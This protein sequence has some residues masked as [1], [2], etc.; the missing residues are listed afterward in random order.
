PY[1]RPLAANVHGHRAMVPSAATTGRQLRAL[2]VWVSK[3][4]LR[5]WSESLGGGAPRDAT[6]DNQPVA[7]HVSLEAPVHPPVAACGGPQ[8]ERPQLQP[9]SDISTPG[10]QAPGAA[11]PPSGFPPPMIPRPPPFPS[12]HPSAPLA[13]A[14]P[15]R[16]PLMLPALRSSL[17]RWAMSVVRAKPRWAGEGRFGRI[18]STMGGGR[19]LWPYPVHHAWLRTTDM[20]SLWNPEAAKARRWRPPPCA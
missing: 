4:P 8:A 15:H 7:K 13:P 19:P 2:L 5:G 20:P 14:A 17:R 18:P 1:A 11:L 3:P 16:Q 12:I 9:H 10:R 6:V